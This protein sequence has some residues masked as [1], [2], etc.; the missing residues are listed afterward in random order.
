MFLS[1][2][3]CDFQTNLYF[4]ELFL[5]KWIFENRAKKV[6]SRNLSQNSAYRL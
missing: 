6:K 5:R 3:M 1:V 4:D 2:R